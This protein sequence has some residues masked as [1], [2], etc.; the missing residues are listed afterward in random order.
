MLIE[1]TVTILKSEYE[2]LIAS[3]K[4]V[5]ELDAL[6]VELRAEIVL[7][8]A[9]VKSLKEEIHFLK[10]GKNSNNSSTPPS[11]DIGRSN[12]KSLREKG[13]KKSGGQIG[14][15]GNTLLVTNNPD[16]IIEYNEIN[17]CTSCTQSLHHVTSELLAT[18]QEII[19]PPIQPLYV[20]HRSFKKVCNQCGHLNKSE[21]PNHLTANIQ[22]GNCVQSLIA[23]MHTYQFLSINRMADFMQNV[24]QMP[25][26]EGTI[27]NLLTKFANKTTPIYNTIQ[28]RITQS[29]VI[30]SDETGSKIN[31]KKGWFHVWQTPMLTFIVASMSRGFG[32]VE[33]YFKDGFPFATLVSDCWAGQ[34]KTISKHHQLCIAHLLRELNNFIEVLQDEWSKDLKQI[35]DQAIAIKKQSYKTGLGAHENE[36]IKINQSLDKLLEINDTPKHKKINAFIKRLRK[37]KSSIFVFLEIEEVPFD[38]NASERAIRNIKVK[39]KISGCFRTLNGAERF[40]K[41]RSV[42]DTTI[43]N[44][45]NVFE[46]LNLLANF[47]VAE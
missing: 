47:K 23:Y 46:A 24:L 39:T 41:I 31:A 25:I 14:H 32:T 35:L 26:S 22:Y 1:A 40:A 8:R 37:H 15:E 9:E 20:E 13:N 5:V 7:L 38:N 29:K 21:L 43:K 36:I 16:K 17:Y 19:L 42:I 10:N 27:D 3:A 2:I 44:S 33:K 45:Q 6:V 4:R 12:A 34:L 11:H 28:Q 30:G 18:K